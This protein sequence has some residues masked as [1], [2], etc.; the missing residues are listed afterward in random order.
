M[1]Q[2][3]L[4]REN[5]IGIDHMLGDECAAQKKAYERLVHAK[6]V[7]KKQRE[8]DAEALARVATK[9]S[10]KNVNTAFIRAKLAE[11]REKEANIGAVGK[12]SNATAKRGWRSI[13]IGCK[14]AHGLQKL[15]Q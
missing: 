8:L 7:V 1:D 6:L 12:L 5:L 10:R 2:K 11:I 15:C 9:R 13:D 4:S 3:L 14:A